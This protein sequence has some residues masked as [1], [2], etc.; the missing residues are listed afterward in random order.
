MFDQVAQMEFLVGTR[1]TGV[2]K[3]EV[4]HHVVDLEQC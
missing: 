2:A 3:M 1:Q 4:T